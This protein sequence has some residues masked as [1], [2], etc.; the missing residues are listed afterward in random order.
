MNKK[1]QVFFIMVLLATFLQAPLTAENSTSDSIMFEWDFYGVWTEFPDD[2]GTL[3]R[4]CFYPRG[5]YS[6]ASNDTNF[7]RIW[8]F[9]PDDQQLMLMEDAFNADFFQVISWDGEQLIFKTNGTE[10]WVLYKQAGQE[11]LEN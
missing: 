3:S 7:T 5:K 8:E 4:I 11:G 1:F 10:N 2:D 6:Y 9:Y